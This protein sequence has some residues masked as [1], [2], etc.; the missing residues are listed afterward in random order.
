[1]ITAF[2]SAI[3]GHGAITKGV[4]MGVHAALYAAL[5]WFVYGWYGLCVI[6]VIAAWWFLLRGR[7]QAQPELQYMDR[8][9]KP[10]NE[11]KDVLKAHYYTG[12]LTCL[13]LLIF[14]YNT[15]LGQKLGWE[16]KAAKEGKWHGK[17]VR[18]DLDG[19]VYPAD[20]PFWDCRRPTEFATGLTADIV[21][22]II[23]GVDYAGS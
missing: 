16:H 13:G 4:V 19:R 15:K 23:L 2:A 20:R 12:W 14:N 9:N 5:F 11:L 8:H 7:K 6:P 21:L 3:H 10:H 18:V 22:F 1:M 17:V